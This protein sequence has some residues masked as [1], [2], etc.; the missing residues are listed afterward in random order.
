MPEFPDETP[1]K[2][3]RGEMALL[4]ARFGDL[5]RGS[6]S[7]IRLDLCALQVA[8][9]LDQRIDPLPALRLLDEAAEDADR[10]GG[11]L[12]GVRQAVYEQRGFR[13]VETDGYYDPLNS[14]LHAVVERRA[15]IP[16][17]LALIVIEVGRR[18]GVEIEGIGA[19]GHFLVRLDG[20]YYDPFQ[21]CGEVDPA[22]VMEQLEQRGLGQGDRAGSLLAAVTKR[23]LL[24]R[25]L[26]N[27]GQTSLD[28]GDPLAA[29][30]ACS[31][32]L[33]IAPWSL[34]HLRDRG[35]LLMRAGLG[36]RGLVDLVEYAKQAPES[37]E[38]DEVLRLLEAIH[39]EA[40]RR[41][42]L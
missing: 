37:P 28:R 26:N 4:A 3:D 40:E 20:R 6:D 35:M 18:I 19:P 21:Q 14:C 41:G 5:V 13:G 32:Q 39:A 17:T 31:Y 11:G 2:S 29:A 23:Q 33:A 10:A 7:A 1:V 9:I 34:P 25:L 22:Q 8:R 36:R 12:D 38:R 30:D 24:Q 15:G 42:A 16:I 27:L